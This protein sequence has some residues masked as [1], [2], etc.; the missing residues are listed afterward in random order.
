MNKVGEASSLTMRK[1]ANNHDCLE[2]SFLFVRSTASA[3]RVRGSAIDFAMSFLP[4]SLV[5]IQDA[6]N[7]RQHPEPDPHFFFLLMSNNVVLQRS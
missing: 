4:A 2:S 6:C 1:A 7:G 5:R 3:L